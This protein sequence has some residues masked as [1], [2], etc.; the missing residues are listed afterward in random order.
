MNNSPILQGDFSLVPVLE[1]LQWRDALP[2]HLLNRMRSQSGNPLP[3]W[4]IQQ[5]IEPM[6]LA[7][8]E[9]IG[10]DITDTHAIEEQFAGKTNEWSSNYAGRE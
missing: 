2:R 10:Q 6:N 1:R 9:L 7:I 3:E 4:K 5:H 8:A